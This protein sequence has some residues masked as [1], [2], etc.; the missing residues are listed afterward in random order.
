MKREELKELKDT[1]IC[2]ECGEAIK[3]TEEA[4]YIKTKRGDE[5]WFHKQCIRK[6]CR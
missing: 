2:Y 1:H 3:P 4:E 5:L 6:R